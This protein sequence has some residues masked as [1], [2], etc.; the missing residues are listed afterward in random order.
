MTQE[1]LSALKAIEDKITERTPSSF[2]WT[3]AMCA[4]WPDGYRPTMS[5]LLA[6]WE[7]MRE[8]AE[9][10]SPKPLEDGWVKH[11]GTFRPAHLLP[12]LVVETQHRGGNSYLG[13]EAVAWDFWHDGPGYWVH[14][15][16]FSDILA[17]R[18]V[19]P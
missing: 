5:G 13:D 18:V 12:G 1:I 17:Y 3:P 10:S 8:A 2:S 6:I 4:I 11:D 16:I 15:G 14:D 19:K 9:Y 7:A